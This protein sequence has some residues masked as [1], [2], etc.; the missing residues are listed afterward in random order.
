MKMMTMTRFVLINKKKLFK[1]LLFRMMKK[2]H[3]KEKK[4]VIN[5]NERKTKFRE[6]ILLLMKLVRFL[7]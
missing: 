5:Q 7:V 6:E 4:N 3:I 1:S 2:I